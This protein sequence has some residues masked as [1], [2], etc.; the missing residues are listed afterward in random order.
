MEAE[1]RSVRKGDENALAYVQTESW[2]AAYAGILDPETLKRY[3]DAG[4]A[5]EMYRKLIDEN[6]G[7]GYILSVE[8]S[9]NM[10]EHQRVSEMRA[11]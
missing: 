8:G 5:T 4:R 7:N 9:R 3:T 10:Q 1:L 11:R 2:K 6:M